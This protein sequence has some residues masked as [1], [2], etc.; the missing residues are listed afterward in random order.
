MPAS[1]PYLGHGVGLRR[2]HYGRALRGELDV[3]WVEVISE[4]FFGDGGRPLAVL[5]RVRAD[6]P[7]VLHGVSLGIGSPEPP[8]ADYLRRLRELSDRIEPAWVSDHLCWGHLGGLYSHELLPLPLT[9]AALDRVVRHVDA[10]QEALGRRILL[11]NVSSYLTFRTDSIPEWEFLAEVARRADSRILLDLNNVL[12]SAHNHG[13]EP[14]EYLRAIPAD[15]VWQFHLARHSDRGAY[16]FDDHCGSVMPEVW[17]LFEAA[18]R[19]YGPVSSLVEWDEGVPPW[20]LLRAEQREASARAEAIFGLSLRI[21]PVAGRVAERVAARAAELGGEAGEARGAAQLGERIAERAAEQL[22]ERAPGEGTPVA[23]GSMVA[24][25]RSP[26]SPRSTWSTLSTLSEDT[27]AL[28]SEPGDA[29]DRSLTAAQRA[30]WTAMTTPGGSAAVRR[31]RPELARSLA[32]LIAETER[33]PLGARID[34]YAQSSIWRLRG[35]LAEIFPTLLWLLGEEDFD[36][37]AARVIAAAPSE[38]P[39]LGRVGAGLPPVL[40]TTAWA[41]EDPW[42]VD[43]ARC[44]RA[45]AE[46]LDAADPPGPVLTPSALEERPPEAWPSL[47]LAPIPALRVLGGGVDLGPL[48]ACRERGEPASEG[49]AAARAAQASGVIA[50]SLLWRRGFE[51][52][53]RSVSEAEAAVLQALCEGAPLAGALDAALA[54]EPELEPTRVVGWVLRWLRDGLFAG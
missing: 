24:P 11:E 5:E 18:L 22:G 27:S 4:N 21:D 29:D 32:A 1:R 40:R 50:G 15:R 3:D 23:G 45:M 26:S 53:R 35:A 31:D 10:V 8:S 17:A 7:V 41:A 43:L 33:F 36:R 9:E 13:F 30:L 46:L 14:D 48:W 44:E 39:D 20:E 42:I 37:L 19:R 38:H 51:V 16:R 28:P 25:A 47:R 2:R 54:A 6:M 34:V 12:V 52:F 49:W